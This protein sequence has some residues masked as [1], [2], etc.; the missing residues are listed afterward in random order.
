[1]VAGSVAIVVVV[2]VKAAAGVV[3]RELTKVAAA[4]E[5]AGEMTPEAAA[6]ELPIGVAAEVTVVFSPSKATSNSALVAD[7]G[8]EGKTASSVVVAGAGEVVEVADGGGAGR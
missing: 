5:A 3:A 8:A 4:E 2:V 1:M 7:S 6:E